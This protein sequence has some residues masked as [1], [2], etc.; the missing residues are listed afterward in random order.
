[1][2]A[3]V[4]LFGKFNGGYTQ[5]PDDYTSEIFEKFHENAKYITQ[6]AIH[7]DGDL[8]YYGYIRNLEEEHYIGMCVVLN[9]LLVTR[10]DTL[11]SLF[12]NAI[13]ELVKKGQLVHFKEQGGIVT[14]VEKLYMKREEVDLLCGSLRAGFNTINDVMA[15]PPVSFGNVNDSLQ[16]FVIDDDLDNIIKSTYTNGYTFI[17]KSKG[18]NT[19]RINSYRG[20][21]KKISTEKNELSEKLA[22]LQAEHERTLR[23]KK[24]FKV[25]LILLVILGGVSM[26]LFSVHESLNTTRNALSDAKAVIRKKE[27]SIS[28]LK[29]QTRDLKSELR[30]EHEARVKVETDLRNLKVKINVR[31]PFIVRSTSFDYDS[32]YLTFNY[33]GLTDANVKISVRAYNDYGERFSS[34]SNVGIHLGEHSASIY[35]SRELNSEC[36]YSFEILKENVIVGGDRH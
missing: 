20:V 27:N 18:Y 28:I 7:R 33:Y 35:V 22:K 32:G 23:Q 16:D 6:I 14:N 21:L 34:N 5:Y 2:N 3:A 10:I 36:W 11:F 9:G 25:V 15:L 24:Q 30:L 8:M 13:F 19:A 1:M 4:Y 17:Y 12:E 31:Q 29:E 26:V